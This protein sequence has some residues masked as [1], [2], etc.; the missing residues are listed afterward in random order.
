MYPALRDDGDRVDLVMLAHRSS[1]AVTNRR[2]YSR[3]A[4]L[5]DP[6]TSRY[7]RRQVEAERTMALHYAVLGAKEM[8]VDEL[9]LASAWACFFGGPPGRERSLPQTGPAFDAL[10]DARRGYLTAVFTS[11]LDACREILNLRFAA[12]NKIA[13]LESPAFA[14]TRDDMTAHLDRLVPP[15]FPNRVTLEGFADLSRYLR[16]LAHRADNLPGRVR[17]DRENMAEAARWEARAASVA[18]ALPGDA[19]VDQIR[20]LIEEYRVGLFSQRIGT[21]ARVSPERL[22]RALE[23]LESRARLG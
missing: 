9:L 14:P 22:A 2:G 16:A 23:P 5:A 10:M 6:R 7:L 17:K 4:L 19:E 18:D 11:V 20:F 1:Q 13:A 3:L 12:A 15:D 8:L 21:K